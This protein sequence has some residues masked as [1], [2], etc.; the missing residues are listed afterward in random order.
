MVHTMGFFDA[1][2]RNL[3]TN[4]VLVCPLFVIYQL[5][6]LYTRPLLNGAD[7]VTILLLHNLQL[8]T[9]GYL[10]FVFGV[11]AAL[12]VAVLTLG[13]KQKFDKRVVLP[14]VLESMVYALTM[15]S[16]IVF[17]MTE[18]MGI[19]PR[20]AGPAPLPEQSIVTRFIMSI[21]AG[22]Y[23]ETVFRLGL[24]TLSV[25]I[26]E[27]VLGLRRWMAVLGGLLFSSLAFSAMHHIPP[28]GDPLSLGV[29]TFRTL[30]GIFFALLFWYRG[31]AVAVYTHALYDIYV[32]VVR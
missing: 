14:V 25:V 13:R 17:V 1:S 30:A 21:G 29:F 23:E 11:A 27:R 24:L 8:S 5:G 12:M 6:V 4:L 26:A 28:Y 16:L 31:F 9:T 18:L 10:A 32:L 20:L 19:S 15:G 22:L 3:L 2:R 7:F